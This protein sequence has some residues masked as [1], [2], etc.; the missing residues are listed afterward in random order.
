M[1]KGMRRHASW[2][3]KI[4]LGV[5]IVTFVLF[6]GYSQIGSDLGQD[7]AI[8]INGEEVPFN[9]YNYFYEIQ[10][11]QFRKIFEGQEMPDFA[12]KSA[13]LSTERQLVTRSL[14]K[15]LAKDLA[16]KVTEQEYVDKVSELYRDEQGEF[17]PISFNRYL[18]Q[19]YKREGFS[20][21][22]LIQDDLLVEKL[23]RFSED[24][25]SKGGARQEADA[26]WQ[27]L[28]FH[29]EVVERPI[30]R[31][32][33]VASQRSEGE[34][35]A[36]VRKVGPISYRERFQIAPHLNWQDAARI[37]SLNKENPNLDPPLK[38]ADK[39]IRVK[40]I[41]TEAKNGK[42]EVPSSEPAWLDLWLDQL[43]KEAK[44][45]SNLRNE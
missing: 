10:Y 22:Q 29:F 41:R 8:K 11:D 9:I 32:A 5:T 34:K 39:E 24:L 42:A 18:E 16:L 26:K 27:N 15:R 25:E 40:W 20:F 13:K 31:K 33:E 21:A 30:E 17:D 14:M 28:Q 1:L 43:H 35:S 45:Q 6:F 38:L 37:F 3:L 19:F 4:I 12:V 36:K 44:V 7:V 2:G 23:S